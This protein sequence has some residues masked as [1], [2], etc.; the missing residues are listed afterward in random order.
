MFWSVLNHR[1]GKLVVHVITNS[2]CCFFTQSV[3]SPNDLRL[4]RPHSGERFH[5][6][7]GLK[8]NNALCQHRMEY[9]TRAV[10]RFCAFFILQTKQF[11][12]INVSLHPVFAIHD[13]FSKVINQIITKRVQRGAVHELS[14]VG[15]EV[16]RRS[17]TRFDINL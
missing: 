9:T 5:H 3:D 6:C 14:K 10:P 16:F 1:I 7:F 11:Q 13:V 8:S 15:I 17:F 4:N 2:C 12:T